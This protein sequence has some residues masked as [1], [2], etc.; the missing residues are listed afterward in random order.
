MSTQL[1][2][3]SPNEIS[4][5]KELITVFEK[6]FEMANFSIPEDPYLQKTLEN[7]DFFVVVYLENDKVIG[8]LTVYV[9]HQYYSTKPLAYIYDLAVLN[10]FQRQGIGQKLIAFTNEHCNKMGYEE[11]FVQADKVDDYAIDFY[12]KT[13]PSG[14][15]EVVHFKYFHS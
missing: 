6:V 3:L 11:T 12:R 9:L 8:G 2:I 14:E 5:F 1:K 13:K 7:P 10:Q 15:D 4:S